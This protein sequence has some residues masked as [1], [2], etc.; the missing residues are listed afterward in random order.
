[1]IGLDTNIMVRYIAQDDRAQSA[2]ASAVI[3]S[4]VPESPGYLPL[5]VIA[6]L[7]WVL[8]S[9]YDF[10]K[11][12][13]V[14]VLETILQSGELV[15]ERADLVWQALRAFRTSSGDLADCLIERCSH[16]AGCD[17][18]LT[19]DRKAAAGAGMKFLS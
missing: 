2:A 5:V 18:T 12:Q 10:K 19:F 13:V 4:L 9:S 1:M 3:D 8:E 16:A 6:E 17:Y 7:I 15:V 14:Q 11:Q